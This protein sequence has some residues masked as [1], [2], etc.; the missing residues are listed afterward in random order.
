MTFYGGDEPLL[1]GGDLSAARRLFP[2]APEP[3][4]DL[5]TGINPVPYP[6]P[7]FSAA[8]FARLPD[9]AS[10]EAVAAAAAR[11][12]GAPSAAHVV[13]APGTQIL[14]PLVAGL[15]RPGRAAVLA[16]TYAELPRAAALA[17]HRVAAVRTV[18]ECA[19][20]T[21]AIVANPNN[22]DGRLISRPALLALAADLRHRGGLLVVDE[23]FM[24]VGP[25]GFSLAADVSVA[26]NI[27]VLRSFGKFFGLGGIRLGF[28]LVAPPLADRLSAMLG[29]WAVSGPALAVGVRA[30][31]DKAWA[32]RT[33]KRLT[34]AA[35]KLDAV[36]AAAGL[37]VTGGTS[38][39]RLARTPAARAL[40]QHLG[41][42][43]IFVRAFP[44]EASWL[45]FGL[46]ANAWDWRRLRSVLA[47]FDTNGKAG[48]LKIRKSERSPKCR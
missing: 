1:H 7:R 48:V 20:A 30:L 43:G 2:G 38:L 29:P 3:F 32:E 33:R 5:S 27:V 10:A 34:V 23:A 22:P 46:P 15:A 14:L 28:A 11:A 36:L 4:V 31:A 35:R 37:D 16:S 13:P 42:A 6:L 40:F 44:D 45:R 17:G 26:G 8:L 19:D 18:D 9:S 47:S 21:L 39:F 41:R 12:Y 24:D 25:P